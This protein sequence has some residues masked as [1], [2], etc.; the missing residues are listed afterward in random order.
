[1]NGAGQL[2]GEGG[3]DGALALYAA[4]AGKGAGRDHDIEVGLTAGPRAGVTV[5]ARAIV[6]DI[7][8]FR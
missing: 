4:H 2:V 7:Q 5:M 1:M 6:L 3:V 8:P